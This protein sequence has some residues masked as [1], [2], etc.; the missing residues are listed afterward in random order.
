MTAHRPTDSV[1]AE[2]VRSVDTTRR[3]ASTWLLGAGAVAVV[4]V[5]ALWRLTTP[6]AAAVAG[7]ASQAAADG[8][9]AGYAATAMAAA[10]KARSGDAA[11]QVEADAPQLAQVEAAGNHAASDGSGHASSPE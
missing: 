5:L 6:D 9:R 2:S 11:A 3:R 8:P 4:S 1:A 7:D 10:G